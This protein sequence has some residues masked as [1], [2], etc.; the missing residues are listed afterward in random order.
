MYIYIYIYIYISISISISIY[1]CAPLEAAAE[2]HPSNRNSNLHPT[3]PRPGKPRA[4]RVCPPQVSL[5]YSLPAPPPPASAP[6][7]GSPPV[8]THSLS[9]LTR[10]ILAAP[11]CRPPVSKPSARP[12]PVSTAPQLPPPVLA[13]PVALRRGDTLPFLSPPP[14]VARSP[15]PMEQKRNDKKLCV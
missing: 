7:L 15:D 9:V 5:V 10:R 11:P 6:P 13:R 14:L 8:L 4:A 1:I 3:E 12:P 2:P